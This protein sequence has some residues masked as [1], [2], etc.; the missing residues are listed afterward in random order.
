MTISGRRLLFNGGNTGKW[1]PGRHIVEGP[2]LE[3]LVTDDG[4]MCDA[5]RAARLRVARP[6]CSNN[7]VVAT[8]T[9]G[10]LRFTV[11]TACWS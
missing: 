2:R 1:Q 6:G 4:G 8:R 10:P 9:I 3:A 5:A 11:P 7:Q